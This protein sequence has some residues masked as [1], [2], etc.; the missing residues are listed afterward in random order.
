MPTE[1][2]IVLIALSHR[3]VGASSAVGS[4]A[5]YHIHLKLA[6]WLRYERLGA[7]E[8]NILTIDEILLVV[9]GASHGRGFR[10]NSI[11]LFN[12]VAQIAQ[13]R[14][15]SFK[16]SLRL[17]RTLCK[18]LQGATVTHVLVLFLFWLLLLKWHHADVRLLKV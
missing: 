13:I 18:P 12:I 10:W 11:L 8:V 2:Y 6:T 15:G 16:L 17:E 5:C 4:R 1:L 7:L 9:I 3:I 14:K